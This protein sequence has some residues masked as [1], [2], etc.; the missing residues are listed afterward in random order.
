MSEASGATHA[1]KET[2]HDAIK[3]VSKYFAPIVGIGAGFV[4]GNTIGGI[5]TIY[6]I[7]VGTLGNN[8]AS[9]IAPAV[10]GLVYGLIG[11]LFWGMRHGGMWMELIGGLAGGFFFGAAIWAGTK[12]LNPAPIGGGLIDNLSGGLQTVASGG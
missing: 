12:I 3:V 5:N 4:V 9:R 7:L 1:A 8:T 6:N 10:M 11:Y 2:F